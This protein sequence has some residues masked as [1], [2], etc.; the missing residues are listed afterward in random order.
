MP[1]AMKTTI[2]NAVAANT[3]GSLS[4]VETACYLILTSNYYNVWH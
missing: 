3:Q 1:A 4:R 2:V